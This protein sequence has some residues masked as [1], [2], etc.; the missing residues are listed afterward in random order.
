ML[1]GVLLHAPTGVS[2]SFMVPCSPKSVARHCLDQRGGVAVVGVEVAAVVLAQPAP[3]RTVGQ[4]RG[5]E[6]VPAPAEVAPAVRGRVA[7]QGD[8]HLDRHAHH[9]A[10]ADAVHGPGPEALA[11]PDRP[12][13]VEGDGLVLGLLEGV[14][15]EQV[16]D[17]RVAEEVAHLLAGQ[18]QL[19][20]GG[21]EVLEGG[22]GGQVGLGRQ[23]ALAEGE[24]PLGEALEPLGRVA[25]LVEAVVEHPVLAAVDRLLA[26][27]AGDLALERRVGDP[28]A[29]V[30]DGPHEEVLAVGEDGRQGGGEVAGDEIAVG[31]EVPGHAGERRLEVHPAGGDLTGGVAGLG[32]VGHGAAPGRG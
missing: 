13:D 28:V 15:D 14:P 7:E 9:E 26:D 27:E 11:A 8:G 23:Q 29:E 4:R 24:P 32:G 21:G 17:R 25:E 5:A 2:R 10:D 31:G 30:A 6:G 18:D 16:P 3:Q 19:G 20:Q 12:V 1:H 22:G